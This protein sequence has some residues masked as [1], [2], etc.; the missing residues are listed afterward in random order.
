MLA[1]TDLNAKHAD[2]QIPGPNMRFKFKRDGGRSGIDIVEGACVRNLQG[3]VRL[4]HDTFQHGC[5]QS[6]LTRDFIWCAAA[7]SVIV[8][9]A[10]AESP[11]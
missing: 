1:V 9:R 5:L 11:Q 7:P 3:E 4:L 8:L 6:A 2:G 10:R